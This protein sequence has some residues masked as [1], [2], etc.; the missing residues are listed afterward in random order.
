MICEKPP[1]GAQALP[2]GA[3]DA[4][5]TDGRTR[6]SKAVAGRD[7]GNGNALTLQRQ[8]EAERWP[9]SVHLV[10]RPASARC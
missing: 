10:P 4:A 3:P 2:S 6:L 7:E 9:L 5:Q 8:R 1:V